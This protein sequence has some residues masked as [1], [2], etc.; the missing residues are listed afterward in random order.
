MAGRERAG[1]RS[2][3]AGCPLRLRRDA[4]SAAGGM[5]ASPP[6]GCPRGPVRAARVS[7]TPSRRT[8]EPRHA[9]A[10]S[11]FSRCTTCFSTEGLACL[12]RTGHRNLIGH[13]SSFCHRRMGIAGELRDRVLPGTDGPRRLSSVRRL[14]LHRLR[15]SLPGR[16][17]PR[18]RAAALHRARRLHRLHALR[19]GMS[20]RGDRDGRRCPG[21]LGG[22][23]RDQRAGKRPASTDRH[24]PAAAS[25]R[26]AATASLTLDGSR[27]RRRFFAVVRA[28][29]CPKISDFCA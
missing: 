13:L 5:P 3:P 25:R 14:P 16:L 20:G 17:L 19:S 6:A 9:P 10:P 24:A 18:G 1:S 8:I 12:G 27:V 7:R 2:P 29:R 4:R 26:A 22:R 11:S 15:R 28:G 23:H 21:G